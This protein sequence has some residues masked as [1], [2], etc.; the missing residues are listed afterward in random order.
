MAKANSDISL[1]K[2]ATL[3]AYSNH[4]GIVTKTCE[5]A[6]ISRET[7][8]KWRK[9]DPE[10][11]ERLEA[12]QPEER[13]LDLAE[14]TLQ[15][16]IADGDTISTIFFLKTKGK[17]RGYIERQEIENSGEITVRKVYGDAGDSPQE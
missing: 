12:I 17:G 7:F 11:R 13:F 3:K 1:Q 14:G 5:A 16:K 15:R 10:F 2:R 6:G 9:D 8:Y 4:F